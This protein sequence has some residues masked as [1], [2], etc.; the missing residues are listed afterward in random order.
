MTLKLSEKGLKR[1]WKRVDE[2]D[3][4]QDNHTMWDTQ[5][6]L[7]SELNAISK[8]IKQDFEPDDFVGCVVLTT[9]E[10]SGILWDLRDFY[11]QIYGYEWVKNE[12][13]FA[14]F[15]KRIEQAQSGNTV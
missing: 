2:L 8:V 9:E 5:N 15:K 7:E 6:R 14:E 3:T 12:P 10:A 13:W 11:K 1:F 4:F